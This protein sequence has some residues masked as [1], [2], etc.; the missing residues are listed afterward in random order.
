[1]QKFLK[2]EKDNLGLFAGRFFR[3][4]CGGNG[5]YPENLFAEENPDVPE[6][7]T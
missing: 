2:I 6:K 4:Q 5:L 7:S 1:L 3:R